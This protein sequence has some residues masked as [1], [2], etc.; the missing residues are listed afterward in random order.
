MQTEAMTKGY[1]IH[2]GN[3]FDGQKF[4]IV[5]NYPDLNKAIT[6]GFRKIPNLSINDIGM[7]KIKQLKSNQ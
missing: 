7:W 2:N 1:T 4:F 6:R 5:S 3:F